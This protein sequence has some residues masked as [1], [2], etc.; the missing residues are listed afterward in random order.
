MAFKLKN[1][2]DFE[3]KDGKHYFCSTLCTNQSFHGKVL[4]KSENLFFL[5][6]IHLFLS[7]LLRLLRNLVPPLFSGL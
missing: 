5:A 6:H 4:V 7:H 2:V 1:Y 3:E